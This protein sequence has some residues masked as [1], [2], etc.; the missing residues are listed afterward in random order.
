MRCKKVVNTN[1][2]HFGINI[3]I[4]QY[5]IVTIQNA[6]FVL[7]IHIVNTYNPTIVCDL[8]MCTWSVGPDLPYEII[9]ASCV[10]MEKTFIMVG[11]QSNGQSLDKILKFDTEI[12]EWKLMN[13]QLGTAR[14]EFTSFLVPDY[15]CT[16]V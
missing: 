10:Q 16:N 11:G 1:I 7:S 9:K 14:Y 13:Q 3:Y 4:Y 12:S 5:T 2:Q 15:Y 6:Y 8:E